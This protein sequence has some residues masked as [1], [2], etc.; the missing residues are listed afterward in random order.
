MKFALY[1]FCEDNSC[2]VGES[3]WMISENESSFNNND[4]VTKKEVLVRWPKAPKDYSKWSNKN[5]KSPLDP[6]CNTKTYTARVLKFH[7]KLDG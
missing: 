4:W 6:E 1:E 2:A 7:G 3:N 5:G